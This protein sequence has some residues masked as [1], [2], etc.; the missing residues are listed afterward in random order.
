MMPSCRQVAEQLSENIDEPL[1]GRRWL[2]LKFHLMMCAICRRYGKQ[3]ELSS[4]SINLLERD[5]SLPSEK[6]KKEMIE[7]YRQ[8]HKENQ[9]K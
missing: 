2:S 6:L 1:T 8:C 9:E 3:I 5:R 4:K 7:H